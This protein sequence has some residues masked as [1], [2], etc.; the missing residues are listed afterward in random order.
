MNGALLIAQADYIV[1]L[2]AIALLVF[3]THAL[4]LQQAGNQTRRWRCLM[5]SAMS[6]AFAALADLPALAGIL[7]RPFGL[8]AQLMHALAFIAL[9]EFARSGSHRYA[10]VLRGRSVRLVVWVSA[11]GGLATV[12]LVPGAQLPALLAVLGALFAADALTR[13]PHADTEHRLLGKP[14]FGLVAYAVLDLFVLAI[15]V[16]PDARALW[17]GVALLRTVVAFIAMAQLGHYFTSFLEQ[18]APRSLLWQPRVRALLVGLL[19][20]AIILGFAITETL[21]RVGEQRVLDD[22]VK[23]TETAAAA[24]DGE[25]VAGLRGSAD[26][27]DSPGFKMLQRTL[28]QV[29]IE[30][31][32][33]TYA[34]VM[35]SIDERAVIIVEGVPLDDTPEPPGTVYEEV[36]PE[37]LR[38]LESERSFLEGP[39]TDRWGTWHSAFAPVY[40]YADGSYTGLLGMDLSSEL[41]TDERATYRLVGLTLALAV[42]ALAIGF[43]VVLQ[44][45]RGLTSVVAASEREYR[46][47]V[48]NAPEAILVVDLDTLQ[49]RETNPYAREWLGYSAEELRAMRF[50]QL[51]VD[52]PR[53]LASI[54]GGEAPHDT[55]RPVSTVMRTAPGGIV[56]VEYTSAPTE[57]D[58]ATAALVFARDVTDQSAAAEAIAL[59]AEFNALITDVSRSF[60]NS[61]EETVSAEI[62]RSLGRIGRYAGVDRAYVVMFEGTESMTNTHEWVDEGV[63]TRIP[64]LQLVP[65]SLYPWIT[66]RLKDQRDVHLPDI[67]LARE[68]DVEESRTLQSAGIRSL[69]IVP[70]A[71]S[72]RVVGFLGFDSIRQ[73]KHWPAETISLLRIVGDIIASTLQRTETEIALRLAKIQ[74]ESANRAKSEFLATMSHEIR[75]PMNAIIGMAELLSDTGLTRQQERY[76]SIFQRAGESLL[77][78][79]NSVLD[80]SKIEADKLE[81]EHAPFDFSDVVETATAV[82]GIRAAEKGLELLYRIKPGTPTQLIGDPERLGQVLLNLIGNAVKFTEKG[83]VLV[84]VEHDPDG[85]AP[86]ALLITVS[87][88]GI[89]IPADKLATIFES[90]T[91]ADSSTTRKYGGTGLGLTI[92]RRL[93]EL[94]GGRM[95]VES[96]PGEGSTFFCAIPFEIAEDYTPPSIE[97]TVPEEF[98]GLRVLVVDDN[99]TNR[100]IVRELLNVWGVEVG[101]ASDGA[102]GLKALR[103]ALMSGKPYRA[104]ILDHQMP[105]MDGYDLLEKVR[106]DHTISTISVVM[107]SSDARGRDSARVRRLGIADYLLKPVRRTDLKEALALAVASGWRP[108]G[109]AAGDA[110]TPGD[111]AS[112]AMR[113]LLVEDS[114]DNRFLIKAYLSKTAHTVTVATNGQE[115]LDEFVSNDQTPFDLVLMDMQMPVMDGYAATSAIRDWERAEGRPRTPI[116]ALTAYA[117]REEAERSIKAGCD[118]HLTKPIKKKDLLGAIA[119]MGAANVG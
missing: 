112:Q 35:R 47:V 58:G 33:V 38:A 70:M 116:V 4:S 9:V 60:I 65:V 25:E 24:L 74:A 28:S 106:S 6:L 61:D 48:E 43:Y 113:I 102:S 96:T 46:T 2:G 36:S 89:G 99:E 32:D 87:D 88:T 12:A 37:L 23:R 115:A 5:V 54:L 66:T 79:I 41:V 42:A 105:G 44:L 14:G 1:F 84:C 30:N 114:E 57:H 104:V 16:V 10:E 72:G 100:L 27:E 20:A 29:L 39:L 117:L 13:L 119:K 49:I 8:V 63:P 31:P 111:A 77:S 21:G 15:A 71:V 98:A 59:Q 52:P 7:V 56:D 45:S 103:E 83:Q 118:A 94:M 76:V 73:V 17:A 69:L 107:L 80:L 55:R 91:Q 101:E 19:L 90:F 40:D 86:G 92:S 78:L 93:V 62:E 109:T 11:I 68:L 81:V 22:L 108:S 85:T 51:M 75:T 18:H 26:D 67:R 95:W 34:Y 53:D 110:L 50:D 64:E 3:S 82:V 97:T